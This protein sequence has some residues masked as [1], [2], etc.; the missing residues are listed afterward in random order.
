MQTNIHRSGKGSSRTIKTCPMTLWGKIVGLKA[1]RC[2]PD[3]QT[4]CIPFTGNGIREKEL[5]EGSST[6]IF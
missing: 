1:I 6:G 3:L 4:N 5:P 2:Y